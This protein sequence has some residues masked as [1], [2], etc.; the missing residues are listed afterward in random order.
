MNGVDVDSDGDPLPP[1]LLAVHAQHAPRQRGGKALQLMGGS[2][3]PSP[4]ETATPTRTARS[5]VP[6]S[7]GKGQ[8]RAA[9]AKKLKKVVGSYGKGE[10]RALAT[11]KMKELKGS[12]G[13]G[14]VR[15]SPYLFCSLHYWNFLTEY[16]TNLIE[17]LI[18]YIILVMKASQSSEGDYHQGGPWEAQRK[19]S[20]LYDALAL[21]CVDPALCP[22]LAASA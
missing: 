11:K 14:E 4:V 21:R 8:H 19:R 7:F 2:P 5:T 18:G 9:M 16:S 22:A 1:P 13:K 15:W 12:Y 17:L 6:M 20:D 10:H 3:P